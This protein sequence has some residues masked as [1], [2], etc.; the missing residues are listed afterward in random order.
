MQAPASPACISVSFTQYNGDVPGEG[1]LNCTA[2][3]VDARQLF[4]DAAEV[5]GAVPVL[6]SR[7]MRL[8]ARERRV[9]ARDATDEVALTPF[10]REALL[11]LFRLLGEAYTGPFYGCRLKL[12]WNFCYSFALSY[13]DDPEVCPPG[14][15]EAL[16]AINAVGAQLES[17]YGETAEKGQHD[18]QALDYARIVFHNSVQTAARKVPFV[19]RV[20]LSGVL[21]IFEFVQSATSYATVDWTRAA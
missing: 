4:W 17:A 8:P 2:R 1:C 19:H 14:L 20:P 5:V 6:P 7:A 21:D 18:S 11:Q 10:A 16:D 13:V 15:K 3:T 12:E 9:A